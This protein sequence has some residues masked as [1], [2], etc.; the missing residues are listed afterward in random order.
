MQPK[1]VVLPDLAG[2]RVRKGVSLQQIAGATKITTRYLEAI[3][4][5]A[6]EKLPGGI[7]NISYIRQ[8]ARATQWDEAALIEYY[9][10][11]F[12][13]AGSD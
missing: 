12:P 13:T 2:H 10:E 3:E 1:P 4:R 11:V 8:Y 9:R 7:Y 5:G 6:F